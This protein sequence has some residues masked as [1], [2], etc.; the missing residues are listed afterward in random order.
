[1]STRKERV[2]RKRGPWDQRKEPRESIPGVLHQ[3][4]PSPL[5]VPSL[6]TLLGC[7][8]SLAELGDGLSSR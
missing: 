3:A 6:T 7:S 5:V 1:V 2:Y 8:P 4:V